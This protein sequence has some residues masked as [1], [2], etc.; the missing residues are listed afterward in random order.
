[1]FAAL[2]NKVVALHRW[3]IGNA[4]LDESLEEGEFRPHPLLRKKSTLSEII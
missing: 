4:E 2:G 1:M 3:R